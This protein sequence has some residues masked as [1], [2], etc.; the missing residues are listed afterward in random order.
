MNG[1]AAL[2]LLFFLIGIA[3]TFWVYSDAKRNSPQSAV[4]WALVA[5]FGGL[6]GLLLYVLLGRDTAGGGTAL[7][8]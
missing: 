2:A 1:A 6:L 4:L 7:N 8:T 3:I 5:F